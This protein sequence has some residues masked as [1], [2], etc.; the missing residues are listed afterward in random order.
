MNEKLEE[1]NKREN[2]LYA[3][4]S[5][6]IPEANNEL[7]NLQREKINVVYSEH[8]L[9]YIGKINFHGNERESLLLE[10]VFKT[11][12]GEKV[13]NFEA[14]Y[15]IPINDPAIA[16]MIVEWNSSP[17]TSTNLIEQITN[18]IEELGGANLTWS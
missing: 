13:Y 14:D 8:N 12:T 7:N 9:A 18:R 5:G 4:W 2:A 11:Y 15:V 1:L 17:P 10:N 6:Q 16:K 3:Y